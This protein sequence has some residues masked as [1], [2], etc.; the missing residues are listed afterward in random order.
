MLLTD[1]AG[2]RETG[3]AVER[4]GVERAKKA[5]A[6][7]DKI[8]TE[9]QRTVALDQVR[10]ANTGIPTDV[11]GMPMVGEMP[12]DMQSAPAVQAPVAVEPPA[13][14]VNEQVLGLMADTQGQ[15]VQAL[16]VMSTNQNQPRRLRV[17]RDP[18]TNEII[19]AESV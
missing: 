3:D 11:P 2:L 13:P 8:T 10:L 6:E 16:T 14:Q 12:L 7:A 4:I 18:D 19:G 17:L 15:L 1:T 9:T 5:L